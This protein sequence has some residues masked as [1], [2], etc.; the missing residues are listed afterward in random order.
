MVAGVIWSCQSLAGSTHAYLLLGSHWFQISCDAQ[1]RVNPTSDRPCF[2][3]PTITEGNADRQLQVP[4]WKDRP[5]IMAKS[6]SPGHRWYR[7][8]TSLLTGCYIKL[9]AAYTTLWAHSTPW[10]VRELVSQ[11]IT[12]CSPSGVDLREDER[13]RSGMREAWARLIAKLDL[14]W[15]SDKEQTRHSDKTLI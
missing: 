8:F 12:C 6:C 13:F 11:I 7:S 15:G 2:F 3:H 14:F 1:P 5:T 9:S 4:K 10:N